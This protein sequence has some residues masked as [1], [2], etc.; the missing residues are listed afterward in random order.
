MSETKR[1]P[2]NFDH[3]ALDPRFLH[4]LARIAGHA[5]EKYGSWEQYKNSRLT[6]EKSPINH[7]YEHLNQ[8]R[9]GENYDRFEGSKK[10][11][12]VAAAYNL[13][14]EYVYECTEPVKPGP[15]PGDKLSK[16][17]VSLAVGKSYRINNGILAGTLCI[18]EHINAQD[19]EV[20]INGTKFLYIPPYP[21]EEIA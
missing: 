19:I 3:N 17:I 15:T 14:M 1:E 4:A 6:G 21:L 13:M 20:N 8:Y 7:I 11:H 5:K 2:V 12:L 16:R 18:L 9:L 10:W